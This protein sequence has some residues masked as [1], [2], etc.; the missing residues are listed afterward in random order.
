MAT[1]VADEEVLRQIV[2]EEVRNAMSNLH[3]TP[4]VD[5]GLPPVLTVREAAKVLQLG[6]TKTYDMTRRKGFPAIRDGWKITIPT[7][8]LFKWLEEEAFKNT[9]DAMQRDSV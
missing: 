2:R 1:V 9:G 4:D 8:A 5:R 7:A 6:V 3:N